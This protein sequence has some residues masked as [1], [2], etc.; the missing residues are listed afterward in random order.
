MRSRK[1]STRMTWTLMQWNY[2]AASLGY[3]LFLAVD[4]EKKPNK[5]IFPVKNPSRS[6]ATHNNR[7]KMHSA[8]HSW[9]WN[10]RAYARA[11]VSGVMPWRTCRILVRGGRIAWPPA[12]YIL[13]KGLGSLCCSNFLGFPWWFSTLPWITNSRPFFRSYSLIEGRKSEK[14]SR[15]RL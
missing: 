4:F 14:K 13:W 7:K 6:I 8:C 11:R 10:A 3:K 9:C 5:K 12:P 2:P 1:T 15:I